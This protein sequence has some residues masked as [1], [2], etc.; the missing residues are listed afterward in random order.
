MVL[1]QPLSPTSA[2]V[3]PSSTWKLTSSTARTCADDALEEALVDREVLAEVADL[4]QRA[5][6]GKR[7]ASCSASLAVEEAAHRCARADNGRRRHRRW[8]QMP[9]MKEGQRGWK[10]QPVGRLWDAA[11][12]R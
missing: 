11:R 3:S 10:G 4:E 5:S 9:G 12:C 6:A 1:P 7:R 8:S 2:S